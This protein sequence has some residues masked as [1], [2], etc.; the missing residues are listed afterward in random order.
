MSWSRACQKFNLDWRCPS[1][2]YFPSNLP[3]L[4]LNSIT[5]LQNKLF[6]KF[7]FFQVPVISC[8]SHVFYEFWHIFNLWVYLIPQ[9]KSLCICHRL[10][11]FLFFWC[12]CG[13]VHLGK[14]KTGAADRNEL[15]YVQIQ[16]IKF[17]GLIL[18]SSTEKYK[19]KRK[20]LDFNIRKIDNSFI[21]ENF[22]WESV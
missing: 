1:T 7:W 2:F 8:F 4:S 21:L 20:E 13:H 17:Q 6:Q 11:F 19:D 3:S 9:E 22:S 5:T 18:A 14:A 15:W 16:S 12:L 10:F